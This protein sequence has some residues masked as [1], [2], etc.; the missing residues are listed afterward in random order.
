MHSMMINGLLQDLY[1]RTMYE[2][3]LR[4]N[5]DEATGMLIAILLGFFGVLLVRRSL[6]GRQCGGDYVIDKMCAD[7]IQAAANCCVSC[8]TAEV[9]DVKLKKC[10]HCDLVRYCSVTCQQELSRSMK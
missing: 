8:G 3:V 4:V 2:A 10:D 6:L 1:S 9:D 7:N 5:E